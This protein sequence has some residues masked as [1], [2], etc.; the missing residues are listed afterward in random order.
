MMMR[1]K[2]VSMINRAGATESTVTKMMIKMLWLGLFRASPKSRLMLADAPA[3]PLG[4][5]GPTGP[6]VVFSYA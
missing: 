4:P 5:V 3:A 6:L 2:L 1:V